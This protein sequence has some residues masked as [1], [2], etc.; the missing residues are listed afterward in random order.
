M[1]KVISLVLAALMLMA[2][3]TGCAK[4]ETSG[5]TE[6]KKM[7]IDVAGLNGGMQTFP[8]YIAEKNGW[9]DEENIEV[10]VVYFENGPVQMEAISS[11]DL[12]ATGVGGVLSGIIA[13]GRLA[14]GLNL[15]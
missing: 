2:V 8:I 7:S 3:F 1:K 14:L 11:W 13:Y 15:P 10:N 5:K 4:N 12:A 9:F 6:N